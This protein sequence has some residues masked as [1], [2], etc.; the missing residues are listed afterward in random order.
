[1]GVLWAPKQP[2]PPPEYNLAESSMFLRSHPDKFVPDLHFM[3]IHVPFHLPTYAVPEG[4]WTIGVGLVR[5]ASRGSVRLRS[6]ALDDKPLID[7]GYLAEVADVEAMVR[8]TKLARELAPRRG[9]RPVARAEALP[10]E[11]VQTDAELEDFVRHAAGSYLPPGRDLPHG[12]RARRRRRPVATGPRRGG[13]ARRRRVGDAVD[14][15]GEHEHRRDDHRRA[16]RGPH[17]RRYA[18]AGVG[19][20]GV[21][22]A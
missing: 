21:V 22:G 16:R 3:F 12:R 20:Q 4:S 14:R 5:P 13:P 11:A 2:I 8:G 17:P 10:G 1:M 19:G 6:T 15:L 18:G 7:P 9:L